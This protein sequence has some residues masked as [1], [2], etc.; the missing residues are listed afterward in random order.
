M[1][2][3]RDLADIYDAVYEWKDSAEEARR[4]RALLHREGVGD[5][6]NLLDVACGTGNHMVHLARWYRVTGVDASPRMLAR[7]RRKL[8]RARFH[9]GRMQSFRMDQRY[10]AVICLFSAIGYVRT[11]AELR[12]TLHN[13]SRHLAPGGVLVIEPWID[14]RKFIPNHV[15]LLSS[16]RPERKIARIT[17]SRR[18]RNHSVMD[19]HYLVGVP[20]S[21]RYFRERH[22]MLMMPAERL[23][24]L[25]LGEGLTVRLLAKGFTGRGLLIARRAHAPADGPAPLRSPGTPARMSATPS[26]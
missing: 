12:T 1:P 20:G 6:A 8:P 3:Y 9:R 5:G 13:L 10:D 21:V 2:T 14:P 26:G 16:D 23:R 11:P 18:V 24:A 7:A 22:D 17:V 25:L 4:I 19:M 15:H